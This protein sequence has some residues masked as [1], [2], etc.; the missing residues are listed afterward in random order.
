MRRELALLLFAASAALAQPVPDPVRDKPA[1]AAPEPLTPPRLLEQVRAEYP[2][3]ATGTVRVLVQVDVDPQG[4]PQEPKVLSPPQPG[5]DE[6]ALVAARKLRFEPARQGATPIAVRIQTAFNFAPQPATQTLVADV[7]INLKG[8]VRERG[9]RRKLEGIE[10]AAGGSSALTDKNGHF[11]LRGLPEETPLQIVIAAPGYQRF[12]AQETIPRGQGLTVEYRLQPE[13]S[14]P[15][16]ATVEGERERR[17]ISRTTLSRQET[18]RVPGAQGDAVKIIEDLPGVA[19]TSPIGGGALVI[20]GSKPGD[21]LVY[22][23]GE[24]IPLLFH[25][26]ALS[27]TFN[28]DLL[29]AID[30]IPGNFSAAY[31]DLTG[32]L[33]EVRTRPLR[34]ELHGYA[35]LNLLEAS[36]LVEGAIPEV[37]GLSVALAGRRSY[38]DFILRLVVP[39]DGDVGLTVAPQYYDAQLRIDYKPQGSAHRLSFLALTSDDALGLL[40]KRPTAQDPN[41]SGSIDAETGFQQ[42]RLKH[43]WRKDGASLTTLAMFEKL[44]LRFVV[45]PSNFILNGHDL[46]LRSTASWEASERLGFSAGIDVA[47]RRLQVGAVFR[48]SF[49][50]REGDFNTQAPRP[51]DATITLP[52]TLFNRLS[53]GAWMEARYRIL[54]NLILIPGLRADLYRYSPREAHTTG[55]ITPR[56]SA[57][58]D[59]SEQ[60]AIKAGLGMYSEGAR[61]GDAAQPFGN[62]AVLP[63]RAWQATLGAEVRPLAGVFVSAETFYKSLGDLIVRTSALETVG[64]V[65]RPQLLDNAGAG[66]VYGLEL[67]IRKELSERFFGWIAY[68]LSRSD[69]IDRPGQQRRLFDYDQTH[70]LTAIASW[71][72]ASSWQIG[73]RMRIISGN[74][75]TPVIGSRY[76]ANFDAYLPVYGPLNSLRLPTFHQL[77]VRLDRTWTFDS[78]LL[79]AYLDVLNAY[80]HRSIEGSVY[81]YDFRQHA[82]FEGLPVIPTLGVKGSF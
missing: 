13:I 25:F 44:L 62:P 32:G 80:N 9:T 24:P 3:G 63:E 38:I 76:L 51:D 56:L 50:F 19:R 42:L 16:E 30:Y 53:P 54:P 36:A 5:F 46:F 17:E 26:G 4:M 70:N 18:D 57:R 21:S 48:Q 14:N 77:D 79:D 60:F 43:E 29:E 31:G 71:R 33:V 78:W 27:S 22:L 65:T 49:L 52:P 55:T 7:P 73:A 59:L 2:P 8:Q 11:E 45:G 20:R 66:R 75:D 40:V 39:K 35:N 28:P 15:Y 41:L 61:N 23:D 47:N 68:T 1:R 82:Y 6:A 34:E 69:R 72:F 58:W 81:S 67:L 37:P 10:V 12:T 74:P 64:G